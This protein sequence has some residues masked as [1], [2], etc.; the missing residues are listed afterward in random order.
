MISIVFPENKITIRF[1]SG[2]LYFNAEPHV[3]DNDEKRLKNFSDN[4]QSMVRI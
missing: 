1:S 2:Y 4:T 3:F